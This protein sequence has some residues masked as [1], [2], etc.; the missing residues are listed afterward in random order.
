MTD[1]YY[2]ADQEDPPEEDRRR[3]PSPA[4]QY[5]ADR[6]FFTGRDDGVVADRGDEDPPLFRDDADEPPYRSATI[7]MPVADDEAYAGLGDDPELTVDAD[8]GSDVWQSE[9]YSAEADEADYYPAEAEDDAAE[10]GSP[11]DPSP[12]SGA[13]RHRRRPPSAPRS[14]RRAC[15]RRGVSASIRPRSAVPATIRAPTVTAGWCASSNSRFRP[16]R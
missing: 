11:G 15:R 7:D 2:Q 10:A 14:R 9:P 13:C 12:L 6:A 4:D 5:P 16:W 1:Y 3:R 8:A